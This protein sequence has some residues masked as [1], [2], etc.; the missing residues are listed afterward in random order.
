MRA[1]DSGKI[2]PEQ[3]LPF[4]PEPKIFRVAEI[5]RLIKT[6]L[7]DEIG[8]IWIEGELSNFRAPGSGH[9][10]FTLKDDSAQIAGVMFRGN[11]RNLRFQPADGLLVRVFGQVS[12]YEKSGQYQVIVR[13]M[14][15]SGQGALQAAFEALKKKLA[16]EGLFDEA[17]KKPLPLL[18]RHIGIVTSPTGAAIRDILKILARRFYNL[19]IVLAP[20][21]VQGEGAARDIAEAIA[22]LN[23]R[24]NLDVLIIGRG[25][26]SLE[27]LWCFNEESVARAIARS[28]IPVIS[29]VGHEID[30]T[31]SDFVADLRAPTPS[32][33]AELVIRE[34]A[35]FEN[36]LQENARRLTRS[37]R[38]QF[39]ALRHRW[40]AVSRHHVFHEPAY[41]AQR[42]RDRIDRRRLQMEHALVALQRERQQRLDDLNPRLIRQ[43][44]EWRQ[45]RA[46]DVRR[47]AL[48]LKGLNPLA[49]L[50]RGYSITSRRD[51]AILKDAARVEPGAR[52]VTRLA[53]GSFESEVV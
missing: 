47:L 23:A 8:E 42:H 3:T 39:L 48:L 43:A 52:V 46:Q 2:L 27:D 41:A 6:V 5:T 34:K 4:P 16:A 30:F 13:Q 22:L 45:G 28:A 37:L 33:A 1:M 31:I 26:G 10:Y 38:Q 25:G 17:R 32:A 11:Q 49:V 53:Q 36:Q 21:R 20:A 35:E 51:G 7:E 24:G 12:V 9:F 19:H 50:D 29:A 14:E 40:L 44:G 15:M 18:P